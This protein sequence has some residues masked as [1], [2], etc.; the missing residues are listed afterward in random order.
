MLGFKRA[1]NFSDTSHGYD[2]TRTGLTSEVSSLAVVSLLMV[3]PHS[4]II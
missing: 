3:D 1:L 4:T 2:T